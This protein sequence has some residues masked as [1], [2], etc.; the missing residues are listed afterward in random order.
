MLINDLK[1]FCTCFQVGQPLISIDYGQKN[2]GLAISTPDHTMSFPLQLLSYHSE[3][4]KLNQIV[5]ITREKNICAIVIGLPLDMKGTKNN[6][7]IIIEQFIQKLE[8]RTKLPLFLQDER[9]TSR[10][11]NNLLKTLHIPRKNRNKYD[12]LIAASIILNTTL[13]ACREEII[14]ILT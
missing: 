3:K 6:Q 11:A 2:I 5:H 13:S 10:E 8:K 7:T 4:K 9:L 1:K 14:R 12:D